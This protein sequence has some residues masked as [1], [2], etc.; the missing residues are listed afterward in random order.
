MIQPNKRY[1]IAE[2][3][4]ITNKSLEMIL[5]YIQIGV[6]NKNEIQLLNTKNR[7]RPK[8][9]IK[10]SWLERILTFYPNKK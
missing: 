5:Y 1:S 2:S 9:L 6:V 4:R 8:K 10:G 7:I 3:S